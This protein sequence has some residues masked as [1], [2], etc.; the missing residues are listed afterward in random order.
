MC[1]ELSLNKNFGKSGL[2][3]GP[4]VRRGPWGLRAFG[5]PGRL[6]VAD[7]GGPWRA[8]GRGPAFS[9]TRSLDKLK[10]E[11]IPCQYVEV[12]FRGSESR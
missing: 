2:A 8:V 5:T 12:Y 6:A 7:R 3:G 9:K 11:V 1:V 4:P 10:I